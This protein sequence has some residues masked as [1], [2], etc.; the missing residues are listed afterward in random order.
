[1]ST[2]KLYYEDLYPALR[3]ETTRRTITQ[4]DLETFTRLS[5]DY[6]PLH[7]DERFAASAYRR[8]S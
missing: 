1:M 4:E 2:A 3:F 5:G 7:T 8:T 6:N